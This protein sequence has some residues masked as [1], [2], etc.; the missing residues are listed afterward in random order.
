MK[1]ITST[2]LTLSSSFTSLKFEPGSSLTFQDCN[3]SRAKFAESDLTRIEFDRVTWASRRGRTVIYDELI[4]RDKG[5]GSPE[6]VKRLYRQLKT[7]YEEKKDYKCVGDFHYGEMEMHRLASP[8][9]R[10]FLSP[11]QPLLGLERLRRTPPP[12]LNLVGRFSLCL[13]L[14]PL[15]VGFASVKLWQP[16]TFSEACR[17]VTEKATTAN[18]VDLRKKSCY[19]LS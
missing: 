2:I 4:W 15:F 12:G 7:N 8:W 17:Y 1:L 14:H 16:S 5:E 13:Q 10:H 18:A 11:G 19:N 3:L 6:A 9:R